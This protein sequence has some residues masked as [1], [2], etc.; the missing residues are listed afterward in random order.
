[1]IK[2]WSRNFIFLIPVFC[3]FT[4]ASG[5][6]RGVVSEG[7][8]STAY[9]ETKKKNPKLADLFQEKKFLQ[10]TEIYSSNLDKLN[11]D[12]LT[13]LA[14]AYSELKDY[15]QMLK[16]IDLVVGQRPE[17]PEALNIK[18]MALMKLNKEREALDLVKHALEL[19][20]RYEPAYHTAAEYYDK[21]SNRYELKLLY[22]DMIKN[23]GE[24]AEYV[25][26]LCQIATLDGQHDQAIYN[27]N[28]GVSLDPSRESNYVY[29]GI[30]YKD[31]EK[32][33][34]AEGYL[35][36][37]T[38]KFPHSE[39]TNYSYANYL[40][41]RKNFIE[42]N[43]YFEKAIRADVNSA[44]SL[45]GLGLTSIEINK[46]SRG[47]EAFKKACTLKQKEVVSSIRI[48]LQT[49]RKSKDQDMIQKFEN[50]SDHC[51]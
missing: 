33:K 13:L 42:A 31:Q 27:C 4:F 25:S 8:N 45:I 39:F 36:R 9:Q 40:F 35:K 15:K 26:Q 3:H 24:R 21:K 51:F 30:V 32:W 14:I 48:A 28:R 5:K 6:Q 47:Y 34:S 19:N 37:A 49:V 11:A 18:A 10:V 23:I 16:I 43:K 29:L 41:E 2:R 46:A 22:Q 20:P 7:S 44:R 1:M 38:I 17:E 50:L 12:E